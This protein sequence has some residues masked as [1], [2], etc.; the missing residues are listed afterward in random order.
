MTPKWKIFIGLNL[1]SAIPT[2]GIGVMLFVN[3]GDAPRGEAVYNILFGI[4]A[5]ILLCNC[6]LNMIIVQRYYP[7]TL[8]PPGFKTFQTVITILSSLLI[9]ALVILCLISIRGVFWGEYA[10]SSQR[11]KVSFLIACAYA[12]VLMVTL[13]IQFQLPGHIRRNNQK[14]MASLI[15]SIGSQSP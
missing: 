8:I 1:L 2:L 10:G 4:A 15:D 14:K 9:F 3:L 11:E 12:L 6:L 5:V 7:D 13:I